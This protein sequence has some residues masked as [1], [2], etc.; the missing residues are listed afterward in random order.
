MTRQQKYNFRMSFKWKYF[1][2]KCKKAANYVDFITKQVLS[3]TW[4]LHHLDL[5]DKHYT[6]I[7]DLS[8][9]LPLNK[10]THDFIH[11]L[12]SLWYKDRNILKRIEI[13]LEEMNQYTHDKRE[14]NHGH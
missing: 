11:W 3:K 13:V 12:Y 9:F 8:R 7:S 2:I 4:N 14:D 10:D 5:R 1:R 6:D